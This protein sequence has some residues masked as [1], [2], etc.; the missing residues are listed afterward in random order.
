V[1]QQEL[2]VRYTLQAPSVDNAGKP[3][4]AAMDSTTVNRF[5]TV[6][7]GHDVVLLMEGSNDVTDRD[8]R[9]LSTSIANL[10]Q[11]LRTAKGRGLRPYL[12]TIP[13][14]NP[15]G[16]RG[17]F[18]AGL[19]PAF[20]DQV[21]SLAASENVPLVDVYQTLNAD[22][23]KFIGPDGLHPSIAGY[24]KIAD[25]FFASITQTLEAPVPATIGAPRSM[26][27]TPPMT[28]RDSALRRIR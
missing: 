22:I 15:N 14:Q 3:G 26:T 24:A 10:R 4:E 13:P 5:S 6:L 7:S 17:A 1:L 27:G 23:G 9:L 16:F 11:M 18:G 2:R 19:V 20:D 28:D 25:L 12:A 8:S 21:R